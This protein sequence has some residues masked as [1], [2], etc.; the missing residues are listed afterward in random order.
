MVDSIQGFS[1]MPGARPFAAPQPLT[2]DQ[3]TQIQTI[4]SNYDSSN[5]T[6]DDAKAIFKQF[7]EAGIRPGPGM[8]EAISA[9]GFDA[10]KLRSLGMPEHRHHTGGGTGGAGGVDRSALQTLQ[11]ILSQYDLTGM[12]DDQENDLLTKLNDAGLMK[13]GNLIDLS[14]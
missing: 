6:A 10:D 9:A 12:S 13:A 5:L 11:T 3:K 1:P 8:K 7:R 4:L 14:A 2:D